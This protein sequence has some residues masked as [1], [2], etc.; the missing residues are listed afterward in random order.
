MKTITWD[1]DAN[2]V[3]EWLRMGECNR[4]GACCLIKI[5]IPTVD[6]AD[7][8]CRLGG[9]SV[10]GAGVWCQYGTPN[11]ARLWKIEI[12]EEQNPHNCFEALEGTCVEGAE[13]KG[14]ICTAWPLHP[15]HVDAFDDCSYRFIKLSEWAIEEHNPPPATIRLKPSRR[16]R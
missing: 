14:L 8:D 5:N 3:T 7:R 4:C 9:D 2:I 11:G 12:T 13:C 1:Y 16:S 10:D 15:D 6:S